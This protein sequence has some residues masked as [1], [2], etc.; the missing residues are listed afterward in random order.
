MRTSCRRPGGAAWP[1]PAALLLCVSLAASPAAARPRALATPAGAATTGGIASAAQSTPQLVTYQ[2]RFLDP[3]G[4]P[5][6]G[7]VDLTF[8]LYTAAAGGT[9]LWFET[10]PQVPLVDGVATVMLGSLVTFPFEAFTEPARYLGITV[11]NGAEM[12][13]RM[14][15]TSVPFAFQAERLQGLGAADFEPRGAVSSL[16]DSLAAGDG[17]PP[18][19]GANRVAWN[20]LTGVPDGFADGEDQGATDHG[21][22]T[23]LLDNDHPQYML[24]SDLKNSDGDP[25]DEGSNLVSWNNLTDVPFGFADGTDN[26][27]IDPGTVTGTDVADSSLT[28]IDLADSTVTG[29]NVAP[30]TLAGTHLALH[31]VGGDELAFDSVSG[32]EILDGSVSGADVEDGSLTGSDLAPGAVG[33]AALAGGAVTGAALAAGAVDST[34]IADGGVSGADLAPGAVGSAAL[35]GGAVTGAALAPGAVDSAS[36]AAGGVSGVDLAPGAVDRGRLAD[37][38]VDSS[39]LGEGA[40]TGL[41]IRDES[42]TG[43]DIKNGSVRAVDLMEGAGGEYLGEPDVHPVAA[44]AATVLYKDITCPADGWVLAVATAQGC[45]QTAAGGGEHPLTFSVSAAD[46][47]PDPVARVEYRVVGAAGATQCAPVVSQ[48]LFTVQKGLRTFYVVA[49]GDGAA[50]MEVSQVNLSLIF[51]GTHY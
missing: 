1:A 23:G 38:A 30:R 29:R 14:A 27:G 41:R 46:G 48:K 5:L 13:P 3:E 21:Q 50:T 7:P 35:A 12:T 19:Q 44:A 11:G 6:A 42:I 28:G 15:V 37:A 31:S 25:P 17:S 26:R 8:R 39:A 10:H 51:L 34:S 16:G 33:S 24:R 9:Q 32:A 20:N 40:V 49:Q 45:V 2:G 43:A 47:A 22:L 36:I 18:N 4:K